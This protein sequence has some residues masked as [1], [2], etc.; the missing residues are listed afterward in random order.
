MQPVAQ[1]PR[2]GRM[3][4]R[5]L[6]RGVAIPLLLL[7]MGTARAQSFDGHAF[8]KDGDD[9]IVDG[10]DIRLFGIDAFEFK[11]RCEADGALYPC[12]KIA[13]Q[14]LA[15]KVQGRRRSLRAT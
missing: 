4:A 6:A 11:Q 9:L 5:T 15:K 8:A 2:E 10:T 12:G 14:E 13:K 3:I 7:A 1:E